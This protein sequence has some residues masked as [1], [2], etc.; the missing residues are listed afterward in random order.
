METRIK[1]YYLQGKTKT[2]HIV[3]IK[4]NDNNMSKKQIRE[5]KTNFQDFF[6][7]HIKSEFVN[8]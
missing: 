5:L 2:G 1:N 6:K 8:I 3:I 7:L 4:N